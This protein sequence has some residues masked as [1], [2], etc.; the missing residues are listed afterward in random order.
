MRHSR[1]GFTLIEVLVALSV[2]ALVVLGGRALLEAISS[3]ANSIVLTSA[4]TDRAANAER[5]LR[6]LVGQIEVGK[7]LGSSFVGD[8]QSTEFTTWCGSPRGWTER[9]R[10]RLSIEPV[11]DTQGET[12][13]L[14]AELSTGQ[15]LVL[16]RAH[17]KLALSYLTDAAFGGRW[18]RQWQ[19]SYTA[20]RALGVI[21]DDDTVIVR[22][23][24]RG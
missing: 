2:A 7:A 15:R 14:M 16:Q 19:E 23:G 17:G 8:E 3:A 20:P 24:E 13:T 10:A 6:V 21:I 4:N 9:C 18:T 5:L 1:P 11:F 22:I 12:L